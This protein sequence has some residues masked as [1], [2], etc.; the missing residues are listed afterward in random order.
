MGFHYVVVC[1]VCGCLVGVGVGVGV[2]LFMCVV[3]V[4]IAMWRWTGTRSVCTQGG[5]CWERL[6]RNDMNAMD[7]SRGVACV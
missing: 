1:E 2:V 3:W 6:C 5:L 4:V 7:V